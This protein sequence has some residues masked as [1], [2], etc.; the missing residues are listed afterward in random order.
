MWDL[1]FSSGAMIFYGFLSVG[2]LC[3]H[4]VRRFKLG[5]NLFATDCVEVNLEMNANQVLNTTD[6]MSPLQHR[7]HENWEATQRQVHLH[8]KAN[9]DSAY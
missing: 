2:T 6:G 4:A 3:A 5:H 1:E 7:V 9:Q 8:W